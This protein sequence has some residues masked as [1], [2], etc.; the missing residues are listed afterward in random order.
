MR[1]QVM[2]ANLK[3][4]L[5]FY[6]LVLM[7]YIALQSSYRPSI[8]FQTMKALDVSP[9]QLLTKLWCILLWNLNIYGALQK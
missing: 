6:E 3:L 8:T 5:H 7:M 9:E 2:G 4:P 1:G